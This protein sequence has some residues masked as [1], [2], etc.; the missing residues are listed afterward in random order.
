M[1][2]ITKE[3]TIDFSK[4][5]TLGEFDGIIAKQGDKSSR[6][7]KVQFTNEAVPI[8]IEKGSRVTLNAL[9]PDGTRT[10]TYGSVNDDGT[11]QVEL[12]GQTLT[13]NGPVDCDISVIGA[14]GSKLTSTTFLVNVME[15]SV[16]DGEL[17]SSDDFSVL[18]EL[19]LQVESIT[20]AEAARVRNE[21][22]RQT[23][24][25][26]RVKT[27]NAVKELIE[28]FTGNIP[29]ANST[30]PGC[31]KSGGG[32]TVD[33]SGN[34]TLNTTVINNLINTAITAYAQKEHPI[35]DVLITYNNVNP[36]TRLG[37]GTWVLFAQGKTLIGVDTTDNDFKTPGKT[38]GEKAHKLTVDELPKHQPSVNLKYETAN[39]AAGT[40]IN[41]ALCEP[42]WGSNPDF[43]TAPIG[44][45][46]PH[47]NLPPYI[48]V[49]FWR[50]TA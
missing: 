28:S 36:G 12:S 29:I 39:A 7:L 35:G 46:Q 38:G 41:W 19:I 43:K 13:V 27:N 8:S 2:S 26:E 22:A 9:K 25:Q 10:C 4:S 21:T 47:N 49:Y 45:D 37:F 14:D 11:V 16:N 1:P 15:A 34:V 50:R 23:A 32:I 30:T 48:C 3:I 18:T 24:E 20:T 40:D 44:N 42:R 31:I 33:A 5:N 6:Y 17:E